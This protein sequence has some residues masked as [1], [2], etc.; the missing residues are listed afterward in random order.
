MRSVDFRHVSG[1]AAAG[2]DESRAGPPAPRPT[3]AP[4]GAGPQGTGR[5][6]RLAGCA[7]LAASVLLGAC[8]GGGEPTPPPP[9]PPP[10]AVPPAPTV[11]AVEGDNI[12]TVLE[13]SDGVI[14]S[15]L[16]E[17]G[18]FVQANWQG[19]IRLV[20]A[21]ANGAWSISI[22][23]Q[24][25]PVAGATTLTVIA[26]NSA[27]DSPPTTRTIT[28]QSPPAG[29]TKIMAL[30]DSMLKGDE[31]DTSG[32]QCTA[33]FPATSWRSF[34]GQLQQQLT[35][36]GY[37]YDFIGSRSLTPAS[38]GTD[39]DHEGYSGL[40]VGP[41]NAG[42][43]VRDPDPA[44]AQSC[45]DRST[46]PTSDGSGNGNLIDRLPGIF[47]TGVDPDLIVYFA[48]WNSVY[49]DGAT[50]PTDT[51]TT[52]AK[53]NQLVASLQALRPNARILLTTL[54]PQNGQ[55]ESQTNA[56]IPGY[57]QYNQAIRSLAANNANVYLADLASNVSIDPSEYWDI[58]HWCQPAATKMATE[59]Y[60][61]IQ[62]QNLMN[63]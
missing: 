9:G 33:Q 10:A 63:Q 25:V 39:P 27:G 58:I 54:T 3:P 6:R 23:S 51:S 26:T 40:F 53:M 36:A 34:R 31:N 43:A 59:I 48:G 41:I 61:V 11:E 50:T 35:N 18:S 47:T 21:A 12:V 52:A 14:L 7:L 8:G 38:G 49:C 16:A 55:T 29:P 62:T 30:G 24:E 13:K 28:V 19:L 20:T 45:R 5:G 44:N 42:D 32:N 2:L 17:P 37:T 57:Q 15:G 4:S 1:P 60:N 22:L 46:T 56:S